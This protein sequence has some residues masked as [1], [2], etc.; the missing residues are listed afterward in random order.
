MRGFWAAAVFLAAVCVGL[1]VSW[2]AHLSRDEPDNTEFSVTIRGPLGSADVVSTSGP[3]PRVQVIKHEAGSG[4]PVEPGQRILY[5][6]SSFDGRGRLLAGGDLSAA[7]LDS[8][9]PYN[10]ALTGLPEGS[11]L[12]VVNPQGAGAE[13][14]VIDLLH[15]SPQGTD[16]AEETGV[17]SSLPLSESNGTL[18]M[19]EPYGSIGS[20]ST[21]LLTRGVGDQVFSDGSLF[22][23]YWVFNAESGDLLDAGDVVHLD[24]SQTLEGLAVGVDGL[25]IG[26]R[27]ALLI[28]AAEAQGDHDTIVVLDLLALPDGADEGAE[29]GDDASGH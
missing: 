1:G 5:V 18:L 6:S 11:R 27:V 23:N 4:K 24:L 3:T 28:P 2:G 20:L 17:D 8:T 12:W 29:Q 15:T 14:I 26:S 10:D 25:R 22:V 16:V 7:T 19:T 9:L 13:I 21:I